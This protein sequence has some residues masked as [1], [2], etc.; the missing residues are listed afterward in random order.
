MEIIDTKTVELL[1]KYLKKGVRVECKKMNDPYHPVPVGTKGTV[2]YVDDA[3]S[4]HVKWD[5]GS[6]LN[7]IPFEDEFKVLEK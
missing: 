7:L 3:G 6:G 2:E 5:N 1:R 4:I